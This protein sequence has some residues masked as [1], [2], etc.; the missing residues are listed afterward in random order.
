MKAPGPVPFREGITLLSA[1]SAGGG[2]TDF[3]NIRSIALIR[4]GQTT[5]HDYSQISNS[6][7]RDVELKP[8]DKI[9]VRVRRPFDGLFG[10]GR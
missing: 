2:F 4:N 8:E 5:E 6:P 3:A 10:G 9:L 7:E 1:I